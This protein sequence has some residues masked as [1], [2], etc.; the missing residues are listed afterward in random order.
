MPV[1]VRLLRGSGLALLALA[2]AC[3]ASAQIGNQLSAYTGPNAT[4]YLRPLVD[5]FGADLNSGLFHSGRVPSYPHF[6]V[7]VKVMSVLF[8][9]A[10]RTFPAS[11]E[12]LFNPPQIV[13]A[14]TI[15][16][17]GTVVT[18]P[19]TGG[20]TFSFPGGFSLSSFAIAVPQL[21]F[22]G[23]AGTEGVVR[24]FGTN[25]G[26]LEL[27]DVKLFGFGVRHSISQYFGPLFP[28]DLAG[29]FFWQSFEMGGDLID[30]NALSIGLQ[31]SKDMVLLQPYVGVS[32]DRF[33]MDVH[34]ETDALGAPQ[35][36]DLAFETETTFHLTLGLAMKL[37][38]LNVHGEVNVAD[39]SGFGF[40]LAVGN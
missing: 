26:D 13:Q 28:L 7:E 37:A 2:L 23:F 9:D 1:F 34:Y 38:I 19:G 35:I 8:D 27:G 22:G 5:A 4:G 31:A 33:S 15:I 20:T 17:S 21:R 12:G 16:G 3:P 14:P 39:K 36:V 6:S 10:D 18:V 24:V 29:G 30:T 40:G 25:T 11:T 32:L